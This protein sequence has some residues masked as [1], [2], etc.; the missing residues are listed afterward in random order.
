LCFTVLIAGKELLGTG[1]FGAVFK[2]YDE[3]SERHLACKEVDLGMVN[4]PEHQKVLATIVY[5]CKVLLY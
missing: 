2:I 4:R 3:L 5:V 1:S